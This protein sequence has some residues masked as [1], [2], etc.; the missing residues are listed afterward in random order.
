[1]LLDFDEC[2]WHPDR[3]L[4]AIR[5]VKSS[6]EVVHVETDQGEA[7][8]KGMGNPQGN[9]S[10]A[11]ELVGSRL[12]RICGLFVPD[13]AV[14]QHEL[15][16][17]VRYSGDLVE[18]GPAFVSRALPGSPGFSG[19]SLSKSLNSFDVPLLV[20]FDTWLAN[21]D[22]QPPDDSLDTRPNW[23]NIF[24]IPVAGSYQ[25]AI[26]DHTHCF[27]EG[28]LA[29]A[30]SDRRYELDNRVYGA[31]EEFGP[32]LTEDALR[33]AAYAI[34]DVDASDIERVVHSVPAEWGIAGS[35]RNDWV[36]QMVAR[37]ERIE[38]ILLS[39]LIPQGLLDI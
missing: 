34:R 27:A 8:L 19:T 1:M 36:G 4:R 23:D 17:L 24:F 39:K 37:R 12:A 21:M 3:V 32:Y 22:R 10:L 25:M 38:K 16:E 2:Q 11:F 9:E 29:D 35:V 5:A 33:R 18:F 20:A 28:E 26:F 31:Y 30:L 6:T 15:L 14:I 13:Y 7:Y